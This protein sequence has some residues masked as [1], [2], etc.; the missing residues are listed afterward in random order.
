MW[1]SNRPSNNNKHSKE[2]DRIN[3][4]EHRRSEAN[5]NL[6]HL[7]LSNSVTPVAVNGRGIVVT[8]QQRRPDA[9]SVTDAVTLVTNHRRRVRDYPLTLT[10]NDGSTRQ[11]MYSGPLMA[12]DGRGRHSSDR[13]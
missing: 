5:E 10:A 6:L 2:Q 11:A 13:R 9:E 3:N 1:S 7:L 8:P 12:V 4:N